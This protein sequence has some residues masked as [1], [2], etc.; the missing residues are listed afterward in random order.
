M[1]IVV[2]QRHFQHEPRTDCLILDLDK[3]STNEEL[4]FKK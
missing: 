2:I 4:V 1:R 3:C